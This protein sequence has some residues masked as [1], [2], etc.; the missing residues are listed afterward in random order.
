MSGLSG[1]SFGIAN[2]LVSMPGYGEVLS[3]PEGSIALNR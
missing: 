2:D 3:G 1:T